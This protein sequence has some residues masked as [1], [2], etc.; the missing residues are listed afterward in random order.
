MD[1]LGRDEDLNLKIDYFFSFLFL[2]F[3]GLEGLNS[4]CF[5]FLFLVLGGGGFYFILLR[6]WMDG[7]GRREVGC[8]CLRAGSGRLQ[9]VWMVIGGKAQEQDGR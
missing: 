5:L 3:F 9:R 7:W 4:T 6:A 2:F 1:E 8:S